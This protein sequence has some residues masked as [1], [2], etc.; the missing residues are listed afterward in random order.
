MPLN[1]VNVRRRKGAG[2]PRHAHRPA[3][4][5]GGHQAQ[6][7][8]RQRDQPED[9]DGPRRLRRPCPIADVMAVVARATEDVRLRDAAVVRD[10]LRLS[11]LKEGALRIIASGGR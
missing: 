1:T 8:E 3:E 4:E 11:H 6:D 7:A 10:I 9:E 2:V 5:I